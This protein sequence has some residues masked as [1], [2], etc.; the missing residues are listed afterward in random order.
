MAKANQRR[1]HCVSVR[2]SFDELALLDAKKGPLRRGTWLRRVSLECVP[3]IVPELNKQSWT[4]LSKAA[5]NLN[6][7]VA[8]LSVSHPDGR[9]ELVPSIDDVRNVLAGFRNALLGDFS[10]G[11]ES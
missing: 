3:P 8:R 4:Q 10:E 11:S 2:F 9:L 7:L 5:A 6:Q 1:I